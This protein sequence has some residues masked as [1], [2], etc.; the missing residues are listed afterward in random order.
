LLN[1]FLNL[2]DKAIINKED[3]I[4]ISVI[5]HYAI[6]RPDEEEQS[7]DEEEVKEIDIIKALRAVETVKI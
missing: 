6:A 7:S 2:K 1:E 4:F 5:D 3:N